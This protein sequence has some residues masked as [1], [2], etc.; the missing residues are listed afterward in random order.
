M[1][2]NTLARGN[3]NAKSINLHCHFEPVFKSSH[4]FSLYCLPA[5]WLSL[6]AFLRI[7][8]EH[9]SCFSIPYV[10]IHVSGWVQSNMGCSSLPVA[11]LSMVISCFRFSSPHHKF[12]PLGN[13]QGEICCKKQ[14]SIL[15]TFHMGNCTQQD[16]WHRLKL[17]YTRAIA[18]AKC[19]ADQPEVAFARIYL[20]PRL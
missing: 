3:E 14:Q 17:G 18:S 10:C 2:K 20:F 11:A 19:I 16:D 9:A 5:L 15:C 7:K 1:Q 4:A 12:R 8:C 6:G 13:W